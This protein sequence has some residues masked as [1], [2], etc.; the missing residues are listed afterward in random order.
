MA[1]A[2]STVIDVTI[3]LLLVS[4]SVLTLSMAVPDAAETRSIDG[5]HTVSSIGTITTTIPIHEDRTAHDTIAGH[6]ITATIENGSLG[7]KSVSGSTYPTAVQQ[8]VPD[9]LP[10]RTHLTVRWR[11]Y[12]DAPLRGELSTGTEPPSTADV[13]VRRWTHNSRMNSNES[14]DS[15]EAIALSMSRAYVTRLFPPERTR[16]D[17]VDSRTAAHTTERYRTFAETIDVDI[18]DELANARPARANDRLIEELSE[19]LE[20]D[21]ESRYSSV[22]AAKDDETIG[23]IEF[24][25]RRWEL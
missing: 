19:R 23:E 15:F 18:G 16:L 14:A 3:C 7:G 21:L 10:E 22:S 20:T 9:H 17:L 4:V 25:V 1:R 2:V 13:S 6:F 5:E 24:T 11:P 8:N 12:P